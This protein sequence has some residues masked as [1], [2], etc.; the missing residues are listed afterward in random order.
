M[1]ISKILTK[2]TLENTKAIMQIPNKKDPDK[3]DYF[4]SNKKNLVS[5]E[6]PNESCKNLSK[7]KNLRSRLGIAA[8]LDKDGEYIDCLAALGIG[9]IEVGTVTPRPQ[10]GNDT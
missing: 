6:L 5:T 10:T 8:G 9:F 7:L 2:K 1:T 4:V 3:R